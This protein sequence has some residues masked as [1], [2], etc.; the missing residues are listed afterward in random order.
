MCLG[1]YAAKRHQLSVEANVGV[2]SPTYSESRTI[3]FL[4][5]TGATSTI[6]SARDAVRL[7]ISYNGEGQP[8]W[9]GK[10]LPYVG[11]ACGIGGNIKLYGLDKTFITLI[12]H[13]PSYGERHT[14]FIA[15]LLVAEAK[16]QEVSL[17]G[18]D[19][20]ERFNIIVNSK[21]T[22]VE[23]IRIPVKDTSYF[24]EHA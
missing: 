11:D 23:F 18:M 4:V 2:G 7:G 16:Y 17:L 20:M 3:D 15:R 8:F 22:T 19:L 6:L 21:A 5:D 13:E 24:I 14:E 1:V 12:S 10:G 9:K